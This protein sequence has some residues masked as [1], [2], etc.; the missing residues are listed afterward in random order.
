MKK[1]SDESMT[2][3]TLV[4]STNPGRYSLDTP[5]G[6]DLTGGD[7]IA[8]NLGD[9]W[10]T[11]RVEHSHYAVSAANG[12]R[13]RDGYIFAAPTGGICGL[14]VGMEVRLLS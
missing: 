2:I 7:V 5:D 3:H 12:E 4:A 11:G 13:L 14:C 9:Q 1:M 6:R 10:I 8:I